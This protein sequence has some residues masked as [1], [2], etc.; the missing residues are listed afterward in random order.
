MPSSTTCAGKRRCAGVAGWLRGSGPHR[1]GVGVA[2]R[3]LDASG[4]R[5]GVAG[6]VGDRPDRTFDSDCAIL[7]GRLRP[8]PLVGVLFMEHAAAATD[9]AGLLGAVARGVSFAEPK[10]VELVS[11]VSAGGKNMK[12]VLQLP[13]WLYMVGFIM[14]QVSGSLLL[15]VASQRTGSAAVG[16]FFFGNTVGFCGATCLTLALRTQHPNL[17]FALCQGGA[18][19]VLQL[20]CYVAF[21]FCCDRAVDRRGVHCGGGRLC[22]VEHRRGEA[23]SASHGAESMNQVSTYRREFFTGN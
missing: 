21:G 23:S 6:T 11:V 17:T 15:R 8:A 4:L 19:C 10:M 9:L 22:A 12:Q 3:G 13:P 2:G 18:F 16:L 14:F 5:R 20:A 1:A 7:V